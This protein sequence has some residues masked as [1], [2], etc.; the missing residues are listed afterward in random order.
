M[1]LR[2]L[3]RFAAAASSGTRPSTATAPV[4]FAAA[5][6][7]AAPAP[8]PAAAA[9][10]SFQ[11]PLATTTTTST[12]S[13]SSTTT[14]IPHLCNLSHCLKSLHAARPTAVTGQSQVAQ[15]GRLARAHPHPAPAVPLCSPSSAAPLLGQQEAG[16]EGVERLVGRGGAFA[17]L[18]RTSR[19]PEGPQPGLQAELV[20]PRPH[21][22]HLWSRESLCFR[23]C[24]FRN[25]DWVNRWPQMSQRNAGSG[26]DADAAAAAAVG[27]LGAGAG[28]GVW[29]G[30]GTGVSGVAMTGLELKA[31]GRAGTSGDGWKSSK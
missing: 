24:P 8:A 7:A 9:S 23:M 17:L 18:L 16:V 5:A 4:L 28:A 6:A 31:G 25:Q 27:V 1:E 14:S 15:D 21:T 2:V 30:V 29:V 26:G 3:S 20:E 13:T 22:W 19:R 12:T 11:G 10:A